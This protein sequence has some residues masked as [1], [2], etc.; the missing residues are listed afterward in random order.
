MMSGEVQRQGVYSMHQTHAL[1]ATLSP[2]VRRSLVL[3]AGLDAECS[4]SFLEIV[5]RTNSMQL[6]FESFIASLTP[7]TDEPHFNAPEYLTG[8]PF[9]SPAD[10]FPK[11][12]I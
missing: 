2:Y 11:Q 7:L 6:L 8:L 10:R 12:N 5:P 9:C 1:H 3:D 4:T